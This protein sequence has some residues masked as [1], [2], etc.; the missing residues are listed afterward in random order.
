MDPLL[1]LL[2]DN[3]ALKPAQLAS[4]LNLPEG[5]VAAKIKTYE[6]EQVIL[7]SRTVLNEEKVGANLVRAVIE[8]DELSVLSEGGTECPIAGVIA[9]RPAMDQK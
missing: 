5:E 6:T 7:G 1:K 8:V 3:A 2:R 9:T 4:L